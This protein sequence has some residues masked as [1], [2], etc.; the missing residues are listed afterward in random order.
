MQKGM[1]KGKIEAKLEIA[2]NSINQGLDNQTIS[3]ITGLT[4]EEIEELRG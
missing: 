1:K 2:K 3:L 4:I